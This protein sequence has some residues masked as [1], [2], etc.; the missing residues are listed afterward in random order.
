MYKRKKVQSA[1]E[2]AMK[3]Q[4]GESGIALLFL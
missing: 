2:Q 1:L 3:A 4:E